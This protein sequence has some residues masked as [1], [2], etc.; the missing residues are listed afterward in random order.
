MQDKSIVIFENIKRINEHNAEYWS[1]RE[2]AKTLEYGDYRNFELVIKKAKESCKNSG[3]SIKYHFV[4]TTDMI[5]VGKTATR[6][7]TDTY[8][9]RYACY[10][11][12]QNADPSKKVVAMGQTYFAIQTRKQEVQDQMAK[13]QNRLDLREEITA[14]NKHLFEAASVAG[15]KNYGLFTNYGYM[16]LYGGKTMADIHRNKRLLENQK[17][18]DHMG[19]EELAANI[20]RASQTDAKLRRENIKGEAMANHT[21][22]EVGREVRDTIR[23]LGGTMPENLAT[24]DAISQAK[25]R[26]KSIKNNSKKLEIK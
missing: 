17:I 1:A 3:Q 9:S 16:G 18:L 5:E 24:P 15:V 2:L 10:L 20:F 22:H 7:I 6:T 4:D 8:L 25:K 12:M 23:K 19:S 11:V 14:H 13:D 21:H 26:I